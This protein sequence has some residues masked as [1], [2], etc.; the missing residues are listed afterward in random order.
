MA[1]NE[2]KWSQSAAPPPPLFLGEAEKRL[3]KQINDELI[4]K[5][6]GQQILYY[7]IDTK[8]T[9][10]NMYGEA[11]IKN[12]LPPIRVYCL[13]EWGGY[14]NQSKPI[15]ER[16]TKLKVH[17]HKRRLTDDQDLYVRHG[18]FIRYGV[19]LFE[20]QKLDEPRELFGQ[21]KSKVEI[22]AECVYSRENVFD[23]E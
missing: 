18:D 13:I 1:D 19:D 22:V 15:V 7:P 3:V 20:I 16:R 17:F 14:E 21:N 5:I 11:I 2:N 23:G 10:Y 12:F 6:V 9:H 4:E 8:N